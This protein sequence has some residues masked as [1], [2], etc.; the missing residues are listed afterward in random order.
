[1]ASTQYKTI[2][3]IPYTYTKYILAH[4]E[5]NSDVDF[6]ML[7]TEDI[8][9]DT[10]YAI[11]VSSGSAGSPFTTIVDN[12]AIGAGIGLLGGMGLGAIAGGVGA[13]PGG[14]IGGVGGAASGFIKSFFDLAAEDKKTYV[15]SVLPLEDALEAQCFTR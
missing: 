9:L 14:I 6:S 4:P 12:V 10:S 11:A 3:D 2:D 8:R 7:I 1:M 5:M 13:I 15:L